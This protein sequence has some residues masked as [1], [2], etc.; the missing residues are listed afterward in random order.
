MTNK[1]VPNPLVRKALAKSLNMER[2]T[3]QN[4][5]ALG[6]AECVRIIRDRISGE[7]WMAMEMCFVLRDVAILHRRGW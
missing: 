3:I 7:K 6:H 2:L 1:N 5:R 4:L